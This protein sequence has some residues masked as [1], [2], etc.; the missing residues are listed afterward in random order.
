MD[1]RTETLEELMKKKEQIRIA[2]ESDKLMLE[3]GTDSEPAV[4]IISNDGNATRQLYHAIGSETLQ[5]YYDHAEPAELTELSE[6][7]SLPH[8]DNQGLK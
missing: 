1:N 3:G 8:H 5:S 6:Q 4:A 7:Q 2:K